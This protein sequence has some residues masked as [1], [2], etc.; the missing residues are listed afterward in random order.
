MSRNDERATGYLLLLLLYMIYTV[1]MYI[2]D[3]LKTTYYFLQDLYSQNSDIIFWMIIAIVAVCFWYLCGWLGCKK[4]SKLET[5]KLEPTDKSE[6]NPEP[7]SNPKKHIPQIEPVYNNLGH[8]LEDEAI[9]VVVGV[10]SPSSVY[11]TIEAEPSASNKVVS[12]KEINESVPEDELPVL[13]SPNTISTSPEYDP[14]GKTK[15]ENT[16]TDKD[17]ILA[18]WH[19]LYME[20]I[21]VSPLQI[22]DRLKKATELFHIQENEA[23]QKT[24]NYFRRYKKFE[25]KYE[26]PTT[27]FYMSPAWITLAKQIRQRDNFTCRRCGKYGPNGGGELHVHHIKPR[28]RGGSDDPSNLITL[29]LDC[30]SKQPHHGRLRNS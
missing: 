11:T 21:D 17:P 12:P 14:I 28:G 20:G 15:Y 22:E 29:C 7:I 24:M 4:K 18:I 1:A 3:K 30:H 27:D 13:D 9:P 19:Q 26:V 8:K 23:K 6:V 25:A 5:D 10:H 2:Y 16:L